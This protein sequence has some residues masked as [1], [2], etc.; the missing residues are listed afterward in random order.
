M[1]W[2]NGRRNAE[3]EIRKHTTDM[4][5]RK[6]LATQD[7]EEKGNRKLRGVDNI[8]RENLTVK[9]AR[10]ATDPADTKTSPTMFF[11]WASNRETDS[12]QRTFSSAKPPI[13]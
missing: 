12:A 10:Y 13:N 6:V 11:S 2:G 4:P 9:G 1:C 3:R 5:R 7:V 8:T